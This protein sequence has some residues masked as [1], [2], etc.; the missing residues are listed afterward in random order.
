MKKALVTGITG[1]AARYLIEHLL[2]SDYEVAGMIRRTSNPSTKRIEHLLHKIEVVNGDLTDEYSLCQAIDKT[3]PD[4][5]YNLAAQSLVPISFEEPILTAEVTGMGVLRLL[6]AIKTVNSKIKF[7]QTSS[8]VSG[9]TKVLVRKNGNI[10]LIPIKKLSI[11]EKEYHNDLE[12]LT[13]TEDYQVKWSKVKYAFKHRASNLYL[14]RGSNGLEIKITG[15]HSVIIMD[16]EGNLKEKRVDELSMRDFLISFKSN[17]HNIEYPTFDLSEFGNHPSYLSRSNKQIDTLTLNDDILR[18]CGFY[19]SEGSIYSSQITFTFHAKESYYSNDI[20]E[21]VQRNFEIDSFYE[22]VE[23]NTRKISFNSKQFANFLIKEFGHHAKHKK[24]PDW[25]YKIPYSGFINFMKGYIGDAAINETE[26]RYTSCNKSLIESLCYLSKF[27]GLDCKIS[28]RFN[29]EHLSPQSILIKGSYCWDLIFCTKFANEILPIYK[30]SSK[31]KGANGDLIDS[32]VF[33]TLSGIKNY[34]KCISKKNALKL[35]N[36]P[37]LG[38]ICNSDL[39]IV[40]IKEIKKLKGE[41]WVYDLHVPE[42]QKFIGGN[43]PILLHN[44]EMYGKVREVPQRES[45]PFHPRSPYGAAK[46]FGYWS[47]VNYRESYDMF[48]A[49]AICFNFESVNRGMEFVTKKITHG[50]CKIVRGEAKEL[51]LGNIKAKRDWGYVEDTVKAMNMIL[52]H[53][54]PDDFVISTGETHSVEEFLE[55]AFGY[56]NLDWQ[57]YVVIDPALIRPAEVDLLLGDSSKIKKT[58]GWE[59]RVK[60]HDLVKMM[61]E[62]ELK[63]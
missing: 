21:I 30:C 20:K 18:L 43:Y 5:V 36:N 58:L 23:N 46:A 53:N 61:I 40:R 47:T 45:T 34:K 12:C 9:D 3:K 52:Q 62:A 13:I 14:V 31:S 51:K 8:S 57:K 48:A 24:I 44:S 4:E 25:F 29:E 16:A 42:T 37:I 50:V 33:S 1:Q 11:K 28:K 10:N 27:N 35:S 7:L 39:H 41:R 38:K 17:N 2:E 59:P 63:L 49:N 54:E 22:T 6:N 60:F 55:I 32:R 56:F 26:I 19:V 15:N